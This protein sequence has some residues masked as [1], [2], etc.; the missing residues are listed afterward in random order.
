MIK[1]EYILLYKNT[2]QGQ[3]LENR[4]NHGKKNGPCVTK[5]S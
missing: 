5:T 3:L 1:I 4:G 2:R